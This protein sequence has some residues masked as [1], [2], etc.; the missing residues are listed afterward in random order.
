MSDFIYSSTPKPEGELARHIRAIYHRDPPDTFEYHGPWGSVGVSRNR[1][2]GFQPLDTDTHLWVVVDGPA[3][4][5]RDNRFLTGDDPVAGTRAICDRARSRPV[6]WDDDVSGPFAILAVDKINKTVCAITD[7]LMFIPLYR[8]AAGGEV[9]L[10]THVDALARAARQVGK[11]D[12]VSL[13]DFIL[14]GAIT[15][16]FTAYR[17]IFQCRPAAV[18][19]FEPAHGGYRSRDPEPYWVPRECDPGGGIRDAAE[20]LREGLQDHVNRVTEGMTEVAQFISGGEDCR[21]IAASLSRL[22]KR[23]AFIFLDDMNR[24]GRIAR[25]TAA[26]Y[27]APLHFGFREKMHYLDI[28]SE[29]ST[30]VGSGLA[31]AH[32]HSLGFHQ[33]LGLDHYP[34]VFGGHLSDTLLKARSRRK[35]IRKDP[36][37]FLPRTLAPGHT[38][39]EPTTHPLFNRDL[40]RELDCRRVAHWESVSKFRKKTAHEWFT[41]WPI[42]MRATMSYYSSN[43]RL[44]RSYEPFMCNAATKISAAVPSRWKRNRRLFI[45]AFRPHLA[46][47]RHI[48]H[49]KGYFPYYPWWVNAPIRRSVKAFRRVSSLLGSQSGNQGPWCDWDVIL[50]SAKW[51]DAAA[52]CHDAFDGI[53]SIFTHRETTTLLADGRLTRPQKINLLQVLHETARRAND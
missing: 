4:C 37:P 13:V 46:P 12:P 41:M 3:L 44:F 36:S 43:R 42:A 15:H 53:Q 16:P 33:A 47:S 6:R 40:L 29:A 50:S 31:Y 8:Y 51:R 38:R 7:L 35:I 10:G 27:G 34:A 5:F 9:M 52:E 1:H 45:R 28:L 20:A 26:V 22:P 2:Q 25:E 39:F 21:V 19:V 32:V 11:P 30:L 14:N 49:A 18:H 48:A 23:D 24:E 17:N